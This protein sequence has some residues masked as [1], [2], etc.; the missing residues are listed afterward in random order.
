MWKRYAAI[1]GAVMLAQAAAG[2]ERP[3]GAKKPGAGPIG[4]HAYEAFIAVFDLASKDPEH[5]GKLADTVRLRLRRHKEYFVLDRFSTEDLA[6]SMPLTTPARKVIETATAGSGCNVAFYGTVTKSGADFSAE[7]RC[8]DARDPKKLQVW[9]KT[10][11]DNTQRARGVIARAIVEAFTGEAEWVPPQIGDEI[12]PKKFRRPPVN[13]NGD[14]ERGHKGWDP[15]D[16]VA[17][18]IVKGPKG[19]GKILKVRTDVARDAWIEY[20]RNLRMGK[21]DPRRPPKIARDGGGGSVAG[22]EGV[23]YRSDWINAGAGWR[24]WL[25]IDGKTAGGAKIFIK[26]FL[27]WSKWAEADGPDGLPESSLARLGLTPEKFARMP[28][29]KRKRLI[30]SDARK[31]PKRYRRECYRWYLNFGSGAWGH[32]AGPW[33]PRGGLPKHVQWF[34]IQIY[35]FWPPGEY[36]YDNCWVYKH[37]DLKGPIP[38]EPARTKSFEKSRR[39]TRPK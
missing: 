31:N 36:L 4:A 27:D 29:A 7:V 11:S 12:E 38:E 18:F 19:R 13:V 24:Y 2:A 20:R 21:A 14:F 35:S 6:A 30:A 15:P 28:E 39:K 22:L 23:H 16:N 3:A 9:T 32:G 17:T 25:L 1:L 8:V 33:P 37:P 34:Q 10:F 5:G 26:G